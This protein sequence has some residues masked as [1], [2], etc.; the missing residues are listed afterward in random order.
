M[1]DL[2]SGG[3]KL[4][5]YTVSVDIAWAASL[6]VQGDA[7]ALPFRDG[8]FD[9][10]VCTNV[11]EHIP[12]PGL[13]LQEAKRV[14]VSDGLLYFEVPFLYHFH[15]ATESDGHD[16]LRWTRE[17][18]RA[19]FGDCQILE[20]GPNV[21]CGTA[22]RLMAAETLALLV[23]SDRHT[24]PYHLMRW[25]TSWL[26]YPLSWLDSWFERSPMSSRVAGGFYVLARKVAVT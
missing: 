22:L 11:L 21:G 18:V 9:L 24:G 17:G 12:Q 2:G 23:W 6:S 16:Y 7:T 20:I 13:A 1:L 4:T 19:L 25:A 15:T 26:L 8:V 14:T 10:V 5:P 3:R